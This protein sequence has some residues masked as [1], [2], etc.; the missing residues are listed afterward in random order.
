MGLFDDIPVVKKTG[1]LFD[2]IPNLPPQAAMPQE[3]SAVPALG[4]FLTDAMTAPQSVAL[5]QE[6]PVPAP[7]QLGGMF[8]DIP[9]VGPAGGTDITDRST[10]LGDL[11]AGLIQMSQFPNARAAGGAIKT[12]SNI[13]SERGEPAYRNA[14]ADALEAE[15]PNLPIEE[16][17]FAREQVAQLRQQ[18]I[19][20]D[21]YMTGREDQ[22]AAQDTG[23]IGTLLTELPILA[24]KSARASAIPTNPAA[25]A[26]L[27]PQG[28]GLLEQAGSIAG[29]IADD[30]YG[31][32]R[33]LVLRSLPAAAPTIAGAVAG[34]A[35]GGP[36]GAA[37][38]AGMG[39]FET[40]RN[41]SVAQGLM[42]AAQAAGV[43]PSD[44]AALKAWIESDPTQFDKILQDAQSRGGIIAAFDAATGGLGGVVAKLAA[45][46]KAGKR[47]AVTG[48]AGTVLDPVGGAAGE[49]GAQL[50]TE[51]E[52]SSLGDVAAEA[53]GGLG[54][55]GPT[56]IAQSAIEAQKTPGRELGRAMDQALREGEVSPDI[57][58]VRG[59]NKPQVIVA[60]NM[61]PE[62]ERD[63][64]P[65]GVPDVPPV[66]APVPQDPAPVRADN[67]PAAQGSEAVP[68]E[69]VPGPEGRPV[70]QGSGD[71]VP[72]A[73]GNPEPAPAL[74][75]TTVYT[76]DNKPIE[77]DT[78]VVEADALLTSD[79]DGYPAE[80]QPRDRD[81]AASQA[82]IEGIA[83]APTPARLDQSPESDRGAPIV[84]PDGSVV[85]S[86]NGRI[87]GL[88]RAYERGT[89]EEYRAYIEQNYPEAVGMK[90]PVI[91]R[92]RVTETDAQQFASVS[93]QSATLQMSAVEQA[94]DDA[95]KIT[96]DIIGLYK[97][98]DVG[99][100][101]NRDMIRA[102]IGK[103][104]QTAQGAL[105]TKEGGLTIEGQRRFQSAL[106][107]RAY[108]SDS[109]LKRL[110][111]SPD[112]DIASLTNAMLNAAPRVAQLQEDIKQG[113]VAGEMS[114]FVFALSVATRE[115]GDFRKKG[116]DL[117][118]Y[119]DQI[120]A[121]AEEIPEL[122]D[123]I[124]DA[125]YNPAGTKMVSKKAMQDFLQDFVTEAMKERIDQ[126]NMPGV[127]QRPKKAPEDIARAAAKQPEPEQT[128][129]LF[130]AQGG[131]GPR[132]DKR[133]PKERRAV[134]DKG[135]EEAD[136]GSLADAGVRRDNTG[137]RPRGKLSPKFLDFSFSN[138]VSVY[139]A[140]FRDAGID[141]D[142]A[143]LMDEDKQIDVLSKLLS[144][145][146]GVTVKMP[147]VNVVKKNLVGRKV[148]E[149]RRTITTR[150]ALDQILD[151]YRQM[152][153]LASI[154]GLPEKAIGLELNGKGIELSLVGEKR[155]GALGMFSWGN[156]ARTIT[157][158]GR[159]N[160]FAHE[161]GHALDHYLN[162]TSDRPSLKG[163]LTRA[164]DDAGITATNTPLSP[165]YLLTE[166]FSNL[167]WAVYGKGAKVGALRMRLQSESVQVG[168][169]GKPTPKALAAQKALNQMKAG[170]RPP[171]EYLGDY[172]ASSAEYDKMTGA[173]GYF[174]DAAEMFARAFEAWVGT[175]VAQVSD[176]PQSFLSKGDWAYKSMEDARTAKTF[177][178][179]EDADRFAVA[180]T[181]LNHAMTAVNLFG[182]DA[183]AQTPQ[184]VDIY[185]PQAL[186]KRTQQTSIAAQEKAELRRTIMM[187]MNATNPEKISKTGK[188]A[189]ASVRAF[190]QENINTTA[191]AMQAIAARQK[192]AAAKEAFTRIA[193]M[194]A[195]RPGQGKETGPIYQEEFE[196]KA[197][198]RLIKI[199]NAV[200]KRFGDKALSP[201]Q[202]R[203]L[204]DLLSG[205]TPAGADVNI[206]GLAA[207]LRTILD[208][209]W[210]DLKGAGIEVGYAK[211]YLPHIYDVQAV[212]ENPDEFLTQA[213]KV[214]SL[215]F[216]REV[217]D[218]T[219]AEAQIKDM[220]AII[221][222]LNNALQ[223][224]P[225]GE[226][227]S[228]NRLTDDQMDQIEAWKTARRDLADLKRRLKEAKRDDTKARL[229]ADIAA[230]EADIEAAQAEILEFLKD[231]YAEYSAESWLIGMRV[232]QLSDFGSIGPSARFMEGRVLPKE[233]G[234]LMKDFMQESPIDLI[235]GY[236][237]A[238]ARRAEWAKMFGANNEKLNTM[239][240]AAGA[241]VDGASEADI[242]M[243]KLAVNAAAGR[244]EGSGR[245]W[246]QLQSTA[247]TYGN[248]SLLSL[249]AF[250][251]LPEQLVAGVR[252]GYVRDSLWAVV[253]TIGMIRKTQ[254]ED[255][256]E[257]AETIGLL[258]PA[259]METLMQNRIGAD[260]LE[261]SPVRDMI[262]Q[263][264]F[265]LNGLT[266]LTSFQK[267]VSV[268]IG[269]RFIMRLLREDQGQKGRSLNSVA[270]DTIAGGRGKFVHGELNELG[271]TKDA[272][273]DLLDW[274]ESLDG[275]PRHEDLFAPD[276]SMHPAAEMW[277]RAVSRF[278][279]ESIQNPLKTDRTMR[280]NNPDFAGMYGI[281]S[282]LDSYARYAVERS[283]RRGFKPEDGTIERGAK[284]A[285]N[286][287]LSVLPFV[288]VYAGAVLATALK[289]ALLNG[290]EWDKQD[291]EGNL[292]NWLLGR[293]FANTNLI[294]RAQ[295]LWNL[296]TG[297][298][299][300]RDLTSITSGPY[301]G[302]F[303][304][305]LMTILSATNGRNSANNNSAEWSA[306]Q[307]SYRMMVQPA[308]AMALASFAPAGPV[309][310][311]LS[312]AAL[313]NVSAYDSS[314]KFATALTGEKGTKYEGDAPDWELGD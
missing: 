263:R 196:A 281:M 92:R 165:K 236:A 29:S 262:L 157:L 251:S 269:H 99:S 115:I 123:I 146:F 265:K 300:G 287:A 36:V 56:T 40:E 270:R 286:V 170:T 284:A 70:G 94:R 15:I 206:R 6:A 28:D 307:A 278:S 312:R 118:G 208:E 237:F 35:L 244:V 302:S 58:A 104:P 215:M 121:F 150:E 311:I 229:T 298:K 233:A 184:D 85:E 220:E 243:M 209:I 87:M 50:A 242:D 73:T 10:A 30:P 62:P 60:P 266:P 231:A 191:A 79:Q 213:A 276:G 2:D 290:D 255:L 71:D 38:G 90:N 313:I 247:F 49:A 212:D 127:P 21:P 102:F 291:K 221:R 80:L 86:G 305:N 272:R 222:G 48:A 235:S 246:A 54:S 88:R 39:S 303:L 289:D 182:R 105:T 194:V 136:S 75:R 254:R 16:Q 189:G 134:N 14:E 130:E 186:L 232:G 101:S 84:G 226:T 66:S 98:G 106:F 41:L 124:M 163:M 193:D 192:G 19:M 5:P 198:Q 175:T 158:P 299:Y 55:G 113:R 197:N 26:V 109:M 185:S 179:G 126:M 132:P 97:G 314:K 239:L 211:G 111:E 267:A 13:A 259:T 252:T 114:D 147:K 164:T 31:V 296:Y 214:Y 27:N 219:D 253:Q 199:R 110:A 142:E 59:E 153:M 297:V 285:G 256:K 57:R 156:G 7:Q 45:P 174:V 42:D 238:A 137:R 309:T 227:V 294:G 32:F 207:D 203:Q 37:A 258:A 148:T 91:V 310:G 250:A 273:A 69:P 9:V 44:P 122:S 112:D 277:A 240:N 293:A 78:V 82:Q 228:E 172:F 154:M 195:K 257:L 152:Q 52:I 201:T 143:K 217:I 140:A 17:A 67:P 301:I 117:K 275:L 304:A 176:L 24:E 292:Y 202:E 282:F 83:N 280:A 141:P 125:F 63:A 205:E 53:I 159:S 12:R 4:T 74:R 103:L 190:Y 72:D 173:N 162:A 100:V 64:P 200:K 204:R 108:S 133:G 128:G 216:Q 20:S 181:Q 178:K 224:M 271:I 160:S 131:S 46:L 268:P 248:V 25:A 11:T 279:R 187:V 183:K 169:D 120:D 145:K 177:P 116:M 151:A 308:L 218:N 230:L 283:L 234:T 225:S 144:D 249:S 241:G 180:M 210:Y 139:G 155:L 77:V 261:N 171:Q 34:T 1:G 166:A 76:A 107:T 295:V 18:A 129:S 43:D 119:R 260:A 33:T 274:L 188:A 161:W 65:K 96:G 245:G 138:R 61:P 51:G 168:A 23:A 149:Q 95:A 306:A 8:D 93:N 223:S 288:M 81:R 135:G 264:S 167:M 47:A 68:V 3:P 22:L 89:A